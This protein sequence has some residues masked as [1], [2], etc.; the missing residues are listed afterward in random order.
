MNEQPTQEQ[1]KRRE[2]RPACKE[3][4]APV[5]EAGTL[6]PRCQAATEVETAG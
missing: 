4:G 1:V 2:I 3:C 5:A 6:C